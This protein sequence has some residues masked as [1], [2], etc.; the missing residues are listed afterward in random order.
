MRFDR[1]TRHAAF[2]IPAGFVKAGSRAVPAFPRTR[3]RIEAAAPFP[4]LGIVRV[5]DAL[6]DRADVDIAIVDVPAFLAGI[7]RS[8]AGEFGHAS[9]MRAEADAVFSGK[10]PLPAAQSQREQ[11]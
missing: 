8:A 7:G 1:S 11:F 6:N 3:A 2:K 10:Q 5:A 4:L 9:R